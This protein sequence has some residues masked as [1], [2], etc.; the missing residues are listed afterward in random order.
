M[1]YNLYI[2]SAYYIL[3]YSI[4]AGRGGSPGTPEAPRGRRPVAGAAAPG[5]APAA[6]YSMI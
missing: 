6:A 1:S 5:L 2:T 3:Y 4:G